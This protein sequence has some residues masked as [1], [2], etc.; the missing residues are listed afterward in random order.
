MYSPRL[1]LSSV[2]KGISGYSKGHAVALGRWKTFQL[3]T[4]RMISDAAKEMEPNNNTIVPFPP[5]PSVGFD[6]V[7]RRLHEGSIVLVDV[8]E[9]PERVDPGRIPGSLHVPLSQFKDAFHGDDKTFEAHYDFPKPKPESENLCLHCYAGKRAR[10][11]ATRLQELHYRDFC[12]YDGGFQ[13]WEEQ[14]GPIL[15]GAGANLIF[16][17]Q[18]KQGLEEKSIILIDVRKPHERFHPGRIPGSVNIPLSA[19]FTAFHM[20]PEEFAFTYGFDKP[21]LNDGNSDSQLVLHCLRGKRAQDA[22]DKLALL[23]IET[24]VYKGSFMDWMEQGGTVER[25]MD[26]L[27]VKEG[28]EEGNITLIDVRDNQ[29]LETEGR[30]PGA[31]EIPLSELE[32]AFQLSKEEFVSKYGFERP[33]Q[34]DLIVTSCKIG[35]RAEAACNMLQQ[36]G[37]RATFYKG[38][39]DDWRQHE[40]TE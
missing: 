13:D 37:F 7:K 8:R 10:V 29:E 23:G 34:T 15:R 27:D 40:S 5:P 12:V 16:F 21:C 38:S 14:G 25:H 31:K 18:V 33:S 1:A 28:L 24:G 19:L 26:C 30:I 35:K 2:I 39:Y 22:A 36:L 17:D 9:S 11:A 6:E 3:L 4:L 20:S 32:N